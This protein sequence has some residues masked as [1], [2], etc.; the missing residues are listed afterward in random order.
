LIASL[1][2][3]TASFGAS[4]DALRGLENQ[5]ALRTGAISGVVVD[6]VSGSP[7]AGASVSLGR[8][9]VQRP[10]PRMVTDSKGRFIFHNLPPS[11]EYFLDARRFGY[12]STRYGWSGPGGSSATSAIR[13]IPVTDGQWVSTITIPLWRY[14]AIGGRVVDER[15]EP[16]VGVAVR[17]F[18]FSNIAGQSQLVGGPLAT[19][20]DRGI[21]R[22]A[23]V[24]PGR[25]IVSVLS[26]Q[27]TVL[28]TTPEGPPVRAVGELESGG[29]G[30]GRG[31]ILT[32]PGID[33][34]G[35]HRLV[36]TNFATPPPPADG[37]SRAYPA[38]FFPGVLRA[39]DAAPIEIAF[40]DNRTGVD[41]QLRPEPG[42]R[43]TGRLESRSELPASLLLRLMPIGSERLG[44]G[45]EAA[46]TTSDRDGSFTF[47]NVP[48][49]N[50]TI[51]AQAAIVEVSSSDP[52]LR[53][54]EPP[55][56]PGGGISIGSSRGAP[57]LSYHVRSGQPSPLS[58]RAPV[59][60]GATDVTNLTVALSPSVTISGRVVFAEGAPPENLHL[61]LTA[62]T[63]DGDLSL[64]QPRGSGV[65][66]EGGMTFEVAGLVGGRYLLNAGRSLVF[67]P[68]SGGVQGYDGPLAMMSIMSGGRD[69]IDTGFDGSLGNDFDDV[70]L[71]LTT[72]VPTLAGVVRNAEGPAS[73]VVIAFPVERERWVGYGLE[74]RRFRTAP[75]GLDG[76]YR[77]ADLPQGE[78]F[79]V[80]VDAKD[81]NEWTNPKFLATAAPHATRV[82]LK[83]GASVTQD[84]KLVEVVVK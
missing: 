1:A 53:L 10:S 60:V 2:A 15:G 78:Y 59:S 66:A 26:V 24:K 17:A 54:A 43:V 23:G 9:D 20:D 5:A 14:G 35:R 41:F 13:R 74:P 19:T 39:A 61:G 55:G 44:P 79:L 16:V 52:S 42:V 76:T 11:P 45:S 38:L 32:A 72:K 49:G 84:L 33:V 25:Y 36:V 65:A 28:N 47:L 40:G 3:G 51:V 18:G 27:S 82:M 50:Y 8:L 80:A 30:S 7:V 67:S 77:V 29:Y 48:E 69:V 34:D 31:A 63:A 70:V 58:G 64:G 62:H 81:T 56:F 22:L 37:R 83:W 21:Y 46:T 4:G 68:A 73:G 75:S 12:A 57:G 6:A 71:T